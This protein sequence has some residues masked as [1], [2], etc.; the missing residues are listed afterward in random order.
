MI[1][2][3]RKEFKHTTYI[4]TQRLKYVK[5][6]FGCLKGEIVKEILT[7]FKIKC[8]SA[9]SGAVYLIQ[10]S[11]EVFLNGWDGGAYAEP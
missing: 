10:G 7:Q 5:F 9:V 4:I 6:I 3:S 8:L 2:I 11:R 1:Q